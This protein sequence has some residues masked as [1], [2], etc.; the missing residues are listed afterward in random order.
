MYL[1][2]FHL[3]LGRNRHLNADGHTVASE[4]IM[5]LGCLVVAVFFVS[6]ANASDE[7]CG[8]FLTS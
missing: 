6:V 8:E 2:S 1:R 4:V 7:L 3:Q 5:K